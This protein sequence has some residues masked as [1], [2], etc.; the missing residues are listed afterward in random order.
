MYLNEAQTPCAVMS[1]NHDLLASL[2]YKEFYVYYSHVNVPLQLND[3]ATK[4]PDFLRQ[5]S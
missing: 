3:I 2:I 4:G 1:K 5:N